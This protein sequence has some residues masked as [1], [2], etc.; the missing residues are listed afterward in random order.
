MITYACIRIFSALLHG[1]CFS[2]L[3]SHRSGQVSRSQLPNYVTL[4]TLTS[5]SQFWPKQSGSFWSV[6]G[7]FHFP[8]ERWLSRL[9]PF[10]F[11]RVLQQMESFAGFQS[12][13]HKFSALT[14]GSMVMGGM[15]MYSSDFM[16][17]Q[18]L[19]SLF[20]ALRTCDSRA[21]G[22]TVSLLQSVRKVVAVP[23]YRIYM[24]HLPWPAW[25]KVCT[26]SI[27]WWMRSR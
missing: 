23:V 4:L 19:Y 5:P 7:Q 1:L 12:G 13:W 21:S 11:S 9:E 6:S 22:L 20:S 16:P 15:P 3:L 27:D 24:L 25:F 17:L 8:I 18:R 14:L 10:H 26:C 2:F